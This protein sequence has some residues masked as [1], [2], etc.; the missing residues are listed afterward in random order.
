[1]NIRGTVRL[2]GG[3]L[4]TDIHCSSKYLPGKDNAYVAQRAFEQ[5]APGFAS[6]FKPGD[7]IVAGRNFGINSSREQAV[8]IMHLMGVAAIVARSFGRQ[9]FRNTINNGLPAIE[10]EIAGIA[11]D[12]EVEIDLAAGK[13]RVAARRIE[14]AVPQLPPA[15]QQILAEGGLIAFLQKHPDWRLA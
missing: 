10:C 2:L 6:R 11:E 4:N 7:V 1:M 8:H 14:R 12:D 5:I 3:D 9:F 13:V 15:V